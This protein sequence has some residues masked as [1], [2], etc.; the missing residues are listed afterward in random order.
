[1]YIKLIWNILANKALVVVVATINLALRFLVTAQASSLFE[2]SG[3]IT[4][5]INSVT[6]ITNAVDLSGLEIT[7]VFILDNSFTDF[8][9]DSFAAD[10]MSDASGV[11]VFD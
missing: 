2:S 8:S 10:R 5:V 9:G 4:Y 3:N 7:G 6:N 1:M 11:G